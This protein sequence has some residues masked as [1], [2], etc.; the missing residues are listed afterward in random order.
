MKISGIIIL[1]ASSVYL[2]TQIKLF[3]TRRIS[4]CETLRGIISDILGIITYAPKDIYF[5]A[6]EYT[7]KRYSPFDEMFE[8][9]IESRDDFSCV[10]HDFLSV[11][12]EVGSDVAGIVSSAFE[13]IMYSSRDG[14]IS[15]LELCRERLGDICVRNRAECENK[16]KMYSRLAVTG[17]AAICV[18]LV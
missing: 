16:S 6:S 18:I 11:M 1:M 4:Y 14:A 10:I 3:Y 15:H 7:D 5:I 2:S 8:M 9:C 12:H 17:A 13:S